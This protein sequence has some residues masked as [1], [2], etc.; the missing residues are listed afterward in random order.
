MAL[1]LKDRVKETTTTTGTGTLTLAGAMSGFQAFSVIGNTNT[2]YYAIYEPSGT[3]W[4]VG[5][6]TY[7]LVGTTLSR[8]TILASSNAGAAVNFG[9]GT[10]VVFCTYPAGKS[11]YYDASGNVPVTG[12][13]NVTS[14]SATSFAV[15]LNGTTN[16]AFTVDSS[17][18]SQA[19]GFKITGAATG[20]T[21]ALVATDSG[22]NTNLTIN[23]KG[24]GTIGI[25]SVSTGLVTITPNTVVTGTLGVGSAPSAGH[26]LSVLKNATGATVAIGVF[27]N[28]QVQSDVTSAYRGFQATLS[29]QDAAFTLTD[30][31]GFAAFQGTYGA[32]S[33]V[34]N[35]R[36]FSAGSNLTGATNNYGFYGDI[37]SGTNRWNFYANGTASNYFGGS[38]G[39]GATTLTG[40]NL[41]I[42]KTIT[43]AV[44][45]FGITLGSVIQSDVTTSVYGYRTTL[46]TQAAAFTL[47]NIY[48]VSV[49]Q[50]TFGATSAVTNQYGVIIGSNLTGATNNYGF[51][52]NI[53]SGAGRWNFYAGGTA[54]NY[55]A[56]DTGIG[57]TPSTGYVLTV[58]KNITGAVTAGLI[59]A[60]GTAQS[61]VT[62]LAIGVAT[63]LQTQATSFTL[64]TLSHFR[65]N[66]GTIGATSTVT[67]QFGVEIANT[68]TGATNNYGIYSNIAFGTG[69]WNFYAAGTAANFFG[70]TVTIQTASATALTVGLNGSTNPAFTIDSSTASQAAGFKITGAATGGTVALVATDSGSNT[71]LSFNAKGT[72]T[73]SIGSVS[74]GDMIFGGT[75]SATRRVE[76]NT[77]GQAIFAYG[78]NSLTTNVTLQ[79]LSTSS[80]TNHGSTI[81]WRTCT[82]SSAT[83]INSGRIAVIKEQ[84]WTSTA[85]TQDSAM[86]FSTTLDGNLSER[87]RITSA[88]R[89]GVGTTAPLC[90]VHAYAAASSGSYAW[91]Y[92]VMAEANASSGYAVMT[93]T[94]GQAIFG[95][96]TPLDQQSAA[97]IMDGTN[98]YMAFHTVNA[99]ERMRLDNNGYLLIGYTASNGAYPLQVNGQIFATSATIA[100]SDGRYKTDIQPL[101]GALSLITALNPIQFKWKNHPVHKFDTANAT[102]GFIAQEIKQ[103]LSG[104]PYLNSIVKVNECVIEP[105]IL[106]DAG[107]VIKE[108]VTEEFLGIAEGNMIALLTK[109]IQELKAEFDLYKLTRP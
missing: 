29:T 41:R 88:G 20:G 97:I 98:R 63:F 8:D 92:D 45:S 37:A 61:D 62:S 99:A 77:S 82:D 5:I 74:T 71:N 1:V 28:S 109:A 67:N 96:G 64:T 7:T 3:A 14:A 4:E 66:Q 53:A 43:G 91:A 55:F 47:P 54:S 38:V 87:M 52:G 94:A 101:T 11:V 26:N 12:A 22:S 65:A 90:K 73:I 86:T 56:G 27:S 16:P 80:T 75:A 23:A 13:L 72:G 108:A 68:L 25:G 36:G 69:R 32:S 34:T 2:T 76:I 30:S 58:N 100:T 51:Y 39:I 59:A 106:D 81:L 105:E 44:T 78:D 10:K 83:A 103:V 84:L 89:L 33:T 95:H 107:N 79:N 21:V 35:Q 57:S 15:G 9:A 40:Y 93:P 6:G 17:T 70:G 60:V 48:H 19:A 46:G 49:E 31:F 50:G 24:T 18:A 102:V 104:K 85:S 42:D